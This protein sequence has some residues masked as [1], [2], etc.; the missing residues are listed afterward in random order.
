MFLQEAEAKADARQKKLDNRAAAAENAAQA[1]ADAANA[2]VKSPSGFSTDSYELFVG[3]E[4]GN[5]DNYKEHSE[6]LDSVSEHR[7]RAPLTAN[8]IRKVSTVSFVNVS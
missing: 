3:Q 1:A 4:K 6:G 8:K 5:E 7:T 2:I